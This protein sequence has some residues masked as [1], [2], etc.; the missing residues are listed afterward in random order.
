MIH[1]EE[2]RNLG[3]NDALL[4]AVEEVERALPAVGETSFEADDALD[5]FA[6]W[7]PPP[8]AS[9]DLASTTSV[10]LEGLTLGPTARRGNRAA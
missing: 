4:D 9:I 6:G 1:R 2:L 3:W 8:C 5:F 10:A 7:A